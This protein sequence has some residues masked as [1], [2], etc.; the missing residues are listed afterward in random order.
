V[1]LTICGDGADMGEMLNR[2]R[3]YGLEQHIL[4]KGRVEREVVLDCLNQVE[5]V[6]LCSDNEGRPRIL[7]EA[8]AAG[9]GIVA[10]DNP[11]SCEVV[12]DWV[13]QWPY[14]H[15]IPIGDVEAA[16][17]AIL[18]L[19]DSL[20]S[21]SVSFSPPPL[22]QPMDVLYKYELLLQSL[23]RQNVLEVIRG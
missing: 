6:L 9:K 12:N 21:R 15:L 19:A 14:A 16:S 18:D 23:T 13:R 11:G 7:Q 2:I 5:T 17:G 8:I 3:C 22:P 20:R 4:V 1:Y 10:Y